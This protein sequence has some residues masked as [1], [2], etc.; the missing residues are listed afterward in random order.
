MGASANPSSAS[1]SRQIPAL[2]DDRKGQTMLIRHLI[3][4]TLMAASPVLATSEP[5]VR[6]C[7]TRLKPD[8]RMI[9]D[10]AAAKVGAGGALRTVVR[11]AAVTLVRDGKLAM[12]AAPKAARAAAQCL[13]SE[14]GK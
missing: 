4:L 12:R 11:A 2:F 1:V 7:V 14:K 10:A 3:L 13:A 9:Y 8:E 5:Q 6:G